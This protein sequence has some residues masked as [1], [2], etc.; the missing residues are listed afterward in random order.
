MIARSGS[1][2]RAFCILRVAKTGWKTVCPYPGAMSKTER[3][4]SNTRGDR[5]Y[6]FDDELRRKRLDQ[7]PSA[8]PSLKPIVIFVAAF[9]VALA[10][11][12]FGFR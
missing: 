8:N 11:Y 2:G 3:Y 5:R 1:P 7:D 12:Y 4:T 10:V 6:R 9:A